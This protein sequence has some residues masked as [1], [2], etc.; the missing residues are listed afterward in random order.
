MPGNHLFWAPENILTGDFDV[1]QL[2][3]EFRQAVVSLDKPKGVFRVISL[4]G[5]FTYGWPYN[6]PQ[7]A[8]DI[9]PAVLQSLLKRAVGRRS[10]EPDGGRYPF[11][12]AVLS[13]QVA[14]VRDRVAP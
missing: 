12:E 14:C 10:A 8:A 7:D 9:Y 5:S 2:L 6:K 11:S 4:G 1:H 13:G 3:N